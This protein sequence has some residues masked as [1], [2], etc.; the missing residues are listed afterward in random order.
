[1]KFTLASDE[2]PGVTRTFKSF[3]QAAEENGRS[4]IYLGI[5]WQFDNTEGQKLGRQIADF[6]FAN[7]MTRDDDHDHGHGHGHGDFSHGPKVHFV[8]VDDSAP[9]VITLIDKQPD[10]ALV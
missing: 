5:H 6:V 2:L 8:T 9:S 4:R 7:A 3:S 1:M 10:D